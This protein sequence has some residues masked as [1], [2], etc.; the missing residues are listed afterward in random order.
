MS[1]SLTAELKR[2]FSAKQGHLVIVTVGNTL[3]SD[4]GIGPYIAR[5]LRST[6]RVTIIGAQTTP[7]NHVDQINAIHP[8]KVIFIDAADFSGV[9]GEIRSVTSAHVSDTTVSTHSIPLSVVGELIKSDTGAGVYYIGI[10]CKNVGLGEKISRA[11]KKA[12]DLIIAEI[13]KQSS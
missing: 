1:D 9:P 4:D 6:K 2:I 3:R 13:L 5:H 12:A 8:S 10:Q 7:E 11:V